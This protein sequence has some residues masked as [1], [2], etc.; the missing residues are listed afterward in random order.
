M[1]YCV[2]LTGGI[3][4]GKSTVAALFKERGVDIIDCDVISHQMTQS[5]GVAIPAIRRTFG[6]CY[7]D[8][9][10]ALNRPLMRG[11]IFS[12]PA[13]KKQLE[14]ILHPMIR[15]QIMTQVNNANNKLFSPYLMIVIPL[16]FETSCYRGLI[17]RALVV[18]CTENTQ[19]TRT[20]QRSGLDEQ[21]VRTI[22]ASQIKRTDRLQR[23]DDIIYNEG[24][25]KTLC[26]QVDSL[27][28]FY[29]T[30]SSVID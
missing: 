5:G 20:M 16:L 4:S 11:L 10:D 7:I 15:T 28:Q 12:D 24:S 3:G 27:H 9:S 2:G 25:M 14:E 19:I 1:K 6:A 23:A 26:Q 21:S 30:C 8:S 22:M 29:Q 17:Q 13:A 18:D